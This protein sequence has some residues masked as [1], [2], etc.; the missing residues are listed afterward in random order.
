MRVALLFIVAFLAVAL[1]QDGVS[2]YSVFPRYPTKEIPTG[3]V[4]EVV[5]NFKNAG[6][7]YLNFTYISAY[8]SS[9]EN[10]KF[11][12]KNFTGFR[13]DSIVPPGYEVSFSYMFLPEEALAT[14][15][16]TFVGQALYIDEDG[17]PHN[18]NFHE[19]LI[20]LVDPISTFDAQ[21]LSTYVMGAGILGGIGF[22]V[23][24]FLLGGGKKKKKSQSSG[25]VS[26]ATVDDYVSDSNVSGW[27]KTKKN[28]K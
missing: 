22:L 24:K 25:P 7:S 18:T 12:L 16:Y 11:I 13:Y 8:L 27:K 6:Q 5:L 20:S 19:S 1:A 14:G 3:S 28:R 4:A 2:S 21:T 10:S 15:D 26:A 17:V 23:N 9:P